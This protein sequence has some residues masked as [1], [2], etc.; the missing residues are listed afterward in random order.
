MDRW[1]E[2]KKGEKK[3]GREEGRTADLYVNQWIEK[4]DNTMMIFCS[5]I[6]SCNFS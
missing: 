2:E 6:F 3:E 5:K 1:I 4:W